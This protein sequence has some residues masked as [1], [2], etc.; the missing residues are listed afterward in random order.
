MKNN[1]QLQEAKSRFSHVVEQAL[2]HGD[3]F[4]TRHGKPAVVILSVKKYR[5]LHRAGNSLSDFLTASPLKGMSLETSR[6]RDS[7]RDVA[8]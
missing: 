4:V 1:W 3:Q 6:S 2:S 8:L 7:G 5:S